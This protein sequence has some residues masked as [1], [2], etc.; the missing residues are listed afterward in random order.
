MSEKIK[1]KLED[2]CQVC[3]SP[4]DV[5]NLCKCKCCNRFYCLYCMQD[6]VDNGFAQETVI[7]KITLYTCCFC[8]EV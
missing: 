2:Q 1:I 7:G 3:L 6:W 8:V 4:L 5:Y